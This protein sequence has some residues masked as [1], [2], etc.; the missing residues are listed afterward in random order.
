MRKNIFVTFSYIN[1]FGFILIILSIINIGYLEAIV[2]DDVI[3]PVHRWEGLDHNYFILRSLLTQC[4]DM[5]CLF[6]SLLKR[7]ICF[8]ISFVPWFCGRVI[9]LEGMFIVFA[10]YGLISQS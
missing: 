8:L 1:V 4:T 7:N 6:R 2:Y 9:R 5:E 3:D 10:Q